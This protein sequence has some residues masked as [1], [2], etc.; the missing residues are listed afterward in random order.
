MSQCQCGNPDVFESTP[1]SHQ[2]MGEPV[3]PL[4]NIGTNVIDYSDDH[5]DDHHIE[6]VIYITFDSSKF[7]YQ[8]LQDLF[9]I[10]LLTMLVLCMVSKNT[11]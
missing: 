3:I 6:E 2:I 9:T 1:E 5:H 4:K 8:V 7:Y 10:I 11:M